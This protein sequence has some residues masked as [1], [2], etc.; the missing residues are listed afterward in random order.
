MRAYGHIISRRAG[1]GGADGQWVSSMEPAGDIR[2]G[3][4]FQH[5]LIRQLPGAP[6]LP[7][8]AVEIDDIRHT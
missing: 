8:I 1:G 3:D 4:H 2:A 7:H 6:G 5:L